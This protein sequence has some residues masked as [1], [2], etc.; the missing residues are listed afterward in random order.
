MAN[1]CL[2]GKVAVVTGGGGVLCSLM[3]KALASC[4]AKVAVLDRREESAQIVADEI[5]AAGGTAIG[6]AANVLDLAALKQAAPA[7]TQPEETVP[8]ETVPEETTSETTPVEE[9]NE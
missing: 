5:N 6:L 8:E 7:E 4:G 2:D 1:V 3:A 9:N